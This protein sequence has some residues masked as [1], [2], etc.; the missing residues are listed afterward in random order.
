MHRLPFLSVTCESTILVLY[1]GLVVVV[2]EYCEAELDLHYLV[3]SYSIKLSKNT[4]IQKTDT[5]YILNN[6]NKSGPMSIILSTKNK[7]LIFI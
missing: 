4:V 2:P 1:R 7:D 3:T 5:C 6:S